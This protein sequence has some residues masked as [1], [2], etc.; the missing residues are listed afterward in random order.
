M[1]MKY[2]REINCTVFHPSLHP[3]SSGLALSLLIKL[4]KLSLIQQMNVN[5]FFLASFRLLPIK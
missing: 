1:Q 5:I 3:Q 4:Q 2:P